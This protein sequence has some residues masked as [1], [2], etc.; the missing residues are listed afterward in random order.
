[1]LK[2]NW[3]YVWYQYKYQYV[4]CVQEL[5]ILSLVLAVGNPSLQASRPCIIRILKF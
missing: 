1:M 5:Q 4:K 2:L 3:P